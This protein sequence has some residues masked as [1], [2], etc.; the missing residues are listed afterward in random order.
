MVEFYKSVNDF[1]HDTINPT[2]QCLKSYVELLHNPQLKIDRK[3]EIEVLNHCLKRCVD[4]K[5]E[6]LELVNKKEDVNV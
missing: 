2:C 6:L 4:M 5:T 1:L 3:K